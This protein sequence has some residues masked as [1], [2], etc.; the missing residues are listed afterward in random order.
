MIE[1]KPEDPELDRTRINVNDED[2]VR[3]W[4]EKLGTS[5]EKLIRAVETV[6]SN[7]TAVEAY[8][9]RP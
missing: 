8:L 5:K 2:E 6:G 1:I 7:A 3:Y 4:S 9:K